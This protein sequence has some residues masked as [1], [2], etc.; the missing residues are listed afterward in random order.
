[1]VDGTATV[2]DIVD[3]SPLAEF[4]VYRLLVELMNL[5]LIDRVEAEAVVEGDAP[6]RSVSRPRMMSAILQVLVLA[7]AALGVATLGANP[8]APWKLVDRSRE[9]ELL[10]TYVSRNRLERVEQALHTYYL[11]R[12]SMPGSL[13]VLA[14]GG[15]LPP[16]DTVDPWGRLYTYRVGP[17]SYEIGERGP[18]GDGRDEILIH[19]P[20]SASQRMVL[21]GGPADHEPPI[22]P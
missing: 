6:P 19:H 18:A 11:D 17:S 1:L 14:S 12:G 9:T 16:G 21:Q 8:N 22:R 4:D 13:D 7:L 10:K 3:T 2:Q 20:F 5:N 15:Y